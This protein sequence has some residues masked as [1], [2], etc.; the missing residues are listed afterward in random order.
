MIIIDSKKPDVNILYL[1]PLLIDLIL[2]LYLLKNDMFLKPL[3]DMINIAAI[4]MNNIIQIYVKKT[5]II[6]GFLL[7]IFINYHF[8]TKT[9]VNFLTDLK[10]LQST[11]LF[12][13]FLSFIYSG[14]LILKSLSDSSKSLY[15]K[16]PETK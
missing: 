3:I 12:S 10:V 7:I 2:N 15:V 8:F 14:L 11:S 16:Y 4:I 5:Q 9:L 13:L 6:S 1:S